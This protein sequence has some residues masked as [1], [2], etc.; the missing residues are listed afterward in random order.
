MPYIKQASD[1]IDSQTNGEKTPD[2]RPV[3]THRQSV[4]GHALDGS[5]QLD[6]L[7]EQTYANAD[8]PAKDQP[9]VP[10]KIRG[11]VGKDSPR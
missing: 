5:Q 11:E 2:A 7:E 4:F 3:S 1:N 9:I 6:I 8:G 10:P